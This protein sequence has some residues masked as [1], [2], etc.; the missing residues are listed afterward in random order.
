MNPLTY[1]EVVKE[2]NIMPHALSGLMASKVIVGV[3][4]GDFTYFNAEDVL[5][6]KAKIEDGIDFL[7]SP[8][9]APHERRTRRDGFAAAALTGII[10]NDS[11][12]NTFNA[13]GKAL[14]A[15]VEAESGFVPRAAAVCAFEYARAMADVSDQGEITSEWVN[16]FFLETLTVKDK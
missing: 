16:N 8:E 7:A 6:L 9:D 10:S 15:S 5:E 2:L 3:R 12:M 14:G 4:L 11:I 1:N 13:M